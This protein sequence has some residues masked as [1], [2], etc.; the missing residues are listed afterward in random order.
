MKTNIN[1]NQ[2]QLF[3]VTEDSYIYLFERFIFSL[4]RFVSKLVY[5]TKEM[6]SNV[7][8]SSKRYRNFYQVSC[9]NFNTIEEAQRAQRKYSLDGK[10]KDIDIGIYFVQRK[11]FKSGSEDIFRVLIQAL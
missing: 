7:K 3:L 4:N 2:K 11:L 9:G 1:A 10:H 5:S 8:A 6:F